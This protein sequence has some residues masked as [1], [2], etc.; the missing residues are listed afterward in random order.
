MSQAPT[1]GFSVDE[2][3]H[4]NEATVNYLTIADIWFWCSDR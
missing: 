2:T 3:F 1:R 4:E